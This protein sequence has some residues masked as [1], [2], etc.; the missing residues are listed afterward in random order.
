MSMSLPVS[1]NKP[2]LAA[3]ESE[4]D[5]F[6]YTISHD[7]QEP[8]RMISSFVKL[9]NVKCEDQLPADCVQYLEYITENSDRM[10]K[11]IY[12]LVDYSRVERNQ[13]NVV[14]LDLVD[15][16]NDMLSMYS[17]ELSLC[18]GS[19]D[20]GDLPK[21]SGQPSLIISLLKHLLRNSFEA[22]VESRPLHIKIE[23]K[24]KQ[25]HWEFCVG[26]N[27]CGIPTEH[28]EHIFEMF[29]KVNRPSEN[30]GAG[31]A[32]CRAIVKKHGGKMFVDSTPDV[33]TLVYFT[34]PK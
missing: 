24:D 1:S 29:R 33:G 15:L 14:E 11:M 28:Q 3:P 6:V 12:S 7:L 8:L 2:Q 9:L 25:D 31:L 18:E 21:I 22:Y 13:E 19:I 10:K 16:V 4:F 17:H 30:L 23:C 26:D 34:I 27:G 32:I 5:R 20:I